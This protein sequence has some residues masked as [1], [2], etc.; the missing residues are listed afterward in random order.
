MVHRGANFQ[1]SSLVLQQELKICILHNAR[2]F[3]LFAGVLRGSKSGSWYG[4]RCAE[5]CMKTYKS[6]TKATNSRDSYSGCNNENAS[7][8]ALILR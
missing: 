4:L 6:A 7:A 2:L 8:N 5:N 1:P 3:G